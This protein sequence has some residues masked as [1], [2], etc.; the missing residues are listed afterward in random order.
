[1]ADALDKL[2]RAF[3]DAHTDEDSHGENSAANEN[4]VDAASPDEENEAAA[5]AGREEEDR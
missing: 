4:H 2:P 3:P 5:R 1:M